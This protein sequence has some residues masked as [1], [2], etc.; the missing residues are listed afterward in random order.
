MDLSPKIL[1]S[2][3]S[4]QIRERTARTV[5]EIGSDRFIRADLANVSCFNFLAAQNLSKMIKQLGVKNTREVFEQVP[6]SALAMPGL[7]AV[8]LA[9]LGAAFE[10]KG[11]GGDRPLETWVKNHMPMPEDGKEKNKDLQIVT[12]HT[13]KQ[14]VQDHEKEERRAR[15]HTRRDQAHRVRVER[16]LKRQ[17]SES[18]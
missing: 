11:F 3:V 4:N 1:G 10:C 6:P 5:L 9:V 18:A 13:M 7:G 8:S 12:F 14:R 15:K 2:T 16:F 17:K